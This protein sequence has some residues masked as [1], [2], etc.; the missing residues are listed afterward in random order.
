MNPNLTVLADHVRRAADLGKGVIVNL[1]ALHRL[2]P[3]EDGC[4]FWALT[5]GIDLVGNHNG[6]MILVDSCLL[7]LPADEKMARILTMP[8]VRVEWWEP[9]IPNRNVLMP[10]ATITR[11]DNA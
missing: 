7:E 1:E 6:E 4:C 8:V 2:F 5:R 9:P 3:S 11:A 10:E